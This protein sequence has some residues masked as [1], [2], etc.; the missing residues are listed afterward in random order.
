MPAH[1]AAEEY[2]NDIVRTTFLELLLLYNLIQNYRSHCG[3]RGEG[4]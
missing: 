4:I 1:L 2:S 3:E